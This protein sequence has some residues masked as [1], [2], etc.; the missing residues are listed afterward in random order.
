MGATYAEC[1]EQLTQWVGAQ[2]LFFVASAPSALDGHVNCSPKGGDTLRVLGPRQLAY[3]DGLGSGIETVAHVRENGR[4]VVMLCAF[5]GPPRIL[6]FHG[7]ATVVDATDACFP[8]LLARFPPYPAARA[9]ILVDITRIADSCGYGVPFYDF[10]GLR[11]D[12]ASY[13]RKASDK[14]LRRYV[15]D[16]NLASL[17]ALPALSAEAAAGVVIQRPEDASGH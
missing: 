17:D 16:N 4:I 15:H 11:S 14:A 3:L 1:D 10:T 6:R 5:E 8:D 2:R 13:V 12:T 9:V 7:R